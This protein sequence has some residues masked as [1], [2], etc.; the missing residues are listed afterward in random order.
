MVRSTSH[1]RRWNAVP[2]STRSRSN[3]WRIPA[4]YSSSWVTASANGAASRAASSSGPLRPRKKTACSPSWSP[5]RV[6]GPSGLS[7]TVQAKEARSSS[8]GIMEDHPQRG[9]AP[10]G[11]CRHA[12]THPDAV[13][14]APAP[15]G[16]LAG[17]EDDE[18]PL[19]R[20]EHVGA[21]LG[22]WALLHQYELAALVVGAALRED[23]QDLEREEDLAVEILM[24][25]VPV[26]GPVAEDERGR[27]RLA[28]LA[29]ALQ[30]RLVREREGGRVSAQAFAP[31]VGHRRQVGV[32]RGA[33]LGDEL[34]QGVVEVAVAAVAEAVA[35]HLDGRAKAPTVKQA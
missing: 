21:A 4:K 13:I 35:R 31:A 18:G 30:Q 22:A 19:G 9:A 25:R 3:V 32:E 16:A 17:G 14:A 26:A 23:A 7:S 8:A 11:D 20:G 27:P 29:A 10:R 2:S 34:G 1:T 24:Q 28:G 12:V 15:G 6:S 33:Q 5:T